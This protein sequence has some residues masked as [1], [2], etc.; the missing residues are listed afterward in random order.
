MLRPCGGTGFWREGMNGVELT[1][2]GSICMKALFRMS[3]PPPPTRRVYV[4]SLLESTGLA[5]GIRC[6]SGDKNHRPPI[7]LLSAAPIQSSGPSTPTLT[8]AKTV[9]PECWQGMQVDTHG[10][11]PYIPRRDDSG[12]RDERRS[13]HRGA[14][15]DDRSG[16]MGAHSS[17]THGPTTP[18]ARGCRRP[19]G[20]GVPSI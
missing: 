14:W 7:Q 11:A 17:E 4:H 5:V 8:S 18:R 12:D 16:W 2:S 20:G 1:R 19:V 9:T 13:L 3:A 10:Q 15:L 6:L